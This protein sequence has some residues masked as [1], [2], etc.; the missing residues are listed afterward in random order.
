MRECLRPLTASSERSF[1]GVAGDGSTRAGSPVIHATGAS[2]TGSTASAG[3]TIAT[4]T[5]GTR[6]TRRPA[7][8]AFAATVGCLRST[9]TRASQLTRIA[10]IRRHGVRVFERSVAAVAGAL[11]DVVPRRRR[12]AARGRA[13]RWRCLGALV[14]RRARQR[15]R[16]HERPQAGH[17]DHRTPRLALR[18]DHERAG[19]TARVA[20]RQRDV[21]HVVV[22]RASGRASTPSNLT[23]AM[24]RATNRR[25]IH[26]WVRRRFVRE[27]EWRA[28]ARARI[29]T[30]SSTCP[31]SSVDRA[32]LS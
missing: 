24:S 26:G 15:P 9:V 6:G 5:C 8:A 30:E 17:G 18:A 10:R 13:R 3:P 25:P 31:R 20:A 21:L 1:W 11:G 2:A 4:V 19:D 23:S 7:A 14:R 28:S 32:R 29:E 22:H 27:R 12:S 16:E